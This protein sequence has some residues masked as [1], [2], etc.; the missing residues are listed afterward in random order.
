MDF[1][2]IVFRLLLSLVLGG[3][4]GYERGKKN[5]AAGLR[6]YMLVSIGSAMVMMIGQFSQT[7]FG[8]G[9]PSRIAAQV[10]SGIGFLGAGTIILNG[11]NQIRGLTTAAG[12]WTVAIIGI[13]VGTGFYSGSIVATILVLMVMTVVKQV[14]YYMNFKEKTI[15]IY[16]QFKNM[17][18]FTKF[19]QQN[20]GKKIK[21]MDVEYISSSE[22]DKVIDIVAYIT[23]YQGYGGDEDIWEIMYD[24]EGVVFSELL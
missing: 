6:T 10:V 1:G 13:G 8:T 7:V 11:K 19:R 9:D 22:Y 16:F 18:S 24:Q 4:I 14:D 23:F 5:H 3:A 15:H 12:L 21:V 17:K 2:V 20:I